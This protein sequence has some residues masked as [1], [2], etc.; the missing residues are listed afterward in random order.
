MKKFIYIVLSII[1]LLSTITFMP[2][3]DKEDT[4]KTN[5][6][7][8][9]VSKITFV[10]DGESIT[11][12]STKEY[13]YKTTRNIT[14]ND[15]LLKAKEKAQAEKNNQ[16]VDFVIKY[17]SVF[18]RSY[19]EVTPQSSETFLKKIKDNVSSKK[20]I[21]FSEIDDKTIYYIASY[22]GSAS[23]LDDC[24]RFE[25]CKRTGTKYYFVLAKIIDNRTIQI[26]DSSGITTYTVTSYSVT[27]LDKTRG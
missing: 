19:S 25:E 9:V 16:S 27:Y 4:N 7:F 17:L 24:I 18:P 22:I 3:C 13:I 1:L 11:K 10:N 5:D 20:V 6:G 21:Y 2:A 8:E 23:S 14:K 12:E 26:A 15:F